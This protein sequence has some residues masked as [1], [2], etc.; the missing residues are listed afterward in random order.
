MTT[1]RS[2]LMMDAE[3]M[4][5][6]WCHMRGAVTPSDVNPP[7]QLGVRSWVGAFRLFHASC[8]DGRPVEKFVGVFRQD[9]ETIRVGLK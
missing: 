8:G 4:L 1:D 6:L 3:Y 7:P 9:F 2:D 5:A